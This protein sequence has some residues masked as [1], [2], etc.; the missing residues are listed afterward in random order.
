MKTPDP[1]QVAD[2]PPGCQPIPGYILELEGQGKWFTQ[3]GRITEVWSERGVWPTP[4]AAAKARRQFL[5]E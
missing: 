4:A 1:I 3:D 5:K 2:V